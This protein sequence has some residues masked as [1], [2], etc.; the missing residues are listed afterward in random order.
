[1]SGSYIIASAS[2]GAALL[3]SGCHPAVG[4]PTPRVEA[5]LASAPATPPTLAELKNATYKG[6][7]EPAGAIMLKDG[8]WE[9]RPYQP[10]GAARPSVSLASGFRVTGDLDGDGTDE[11]V[12]VL[13]KSSG[14]SGTFDY[15][16]VVKRTA[17][18][19]DNVAT[20]ALGDRVQ[21]RSARIE[22][23]ML[24]VS[25]VRAGD[26]DPMCWP[27]ELADLAWTFA[28][29]HLAPVAASGPTSRLSLDTLAGTEWVLRAWSFDEPA[30]TEPE[31][32]LTYRDGRFAGRSGCNR[33]TAPAKAGDLPGNLSVGPVASTRMACPENESAV[34]ARFLRQLGTAKKF[35]FTLGR[36]GITY[37]AED[38]GLGT[39][40]FDG[41]TLPP[42]AKP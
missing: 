12:V 32:T 7:E 38:G 26:N 8:R 21:I 16:A 4:V 17:T 10:G 6:L 18:G 13:A 36:L 20:V 9:G 30:P 5:G 24:H 23:G 2:W 37:E 27:G 22:N 19:I 3:L 29:S 42:T 14:G 33:Y 41:R 25:V 1:M 15:L 28:G 31:I 40:L 39:M 34:E 35:G 11:S